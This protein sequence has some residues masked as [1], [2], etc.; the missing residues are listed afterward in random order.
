MLNP[1]QP[2]EK[3]GLEKAIDTVFREM[4]GVES[5]SEDYAKMTDQLTKLYSLKQVDKPERIS[6][7]TLVIAAANIFVAFLITKHERTHVITTKAMN[8]LLKLR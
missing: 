8:F 2:D 5:D 4:E 3:P 1:N 7:D 6:R